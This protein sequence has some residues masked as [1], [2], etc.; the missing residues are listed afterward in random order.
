MNSVLEFFRQEDPRFKE[1]PDRE[2]SLFIG[3]TY[4]EFLEDPHFKEIY[5][6]RTEQRDLEKKNKD[7]TELEGIADTEG[8]AAQLVAEAPARAVGAVGKSLTTAGNLA[9][10]AATDVAE[11][12]GRGQI[13]GVGVPLVLP[14]VDA[15]VKNEPL[16]SDVEDEELL[17]R[18]GSGVAPLIRLGM[19]TAVRSAPTLAA[20]AA[21]TTAGVPAPLAYGGTMATQT[22]G[23][24]GSVPEAI[25]SGAIGAIL[26]VVGNIGRKAAGTALSGLVRNG[27]L[28][29]ESET[30]QKVVE[31]I[32]S[33]AAVQGLL[34]AIKIPQY[35]QMNPEERKSALIRSIAANMTFAVMELPQFAKGVPSETQ[36]A[37][38]NDAGYM[39]SRL[40][41]KGPILEAS[42][43]E[44][45]GMLADPRSAQEFQKVV[46]GEEPPAATEQR[47]AA[48]QTGSP[49]VAPAETQAEAKPSDEQAREALLKRGGVWEASTPVEGHRVSGI[50]TVAEANDLVSSA[51]KGFDQALQP[52]DRS[53]E[54]SGN[55]IAEI[56][57]KFEP[58]RLGDAPTTD[59]GAPIIDE[60]NQVLSGNGRTAALRG[61]YSAEN[62]SKAEAYRAF[63]LKQAE[64]MGSPAEV[65]ASIKKMKQPVL[66]RQVSDLSGLSKEEFAR[67]SNQQQILG[68][69]EA[70]KAA[71]DAKVVSAIADLWR[72]SEEGDVLASSN[73]DFL[74]AF[75]KGT[76]DQAELLTKEGYNAG[77][78]T[79]RVRN[80][81]L[82]NLVGSD[83]IGRE[84]LGHLLERGDEL[85]LRNVVAGVMNAAPA[86]VKVRE[87]KPDY[88]VSGVL[89]KALIDLVNLK[90]EGVRVEDYVKQMD[91]LTDPERSAQSD[92]LVEKLANAKSVK[93][94]TE[95]LGKFA[96]RAQKIDAAR[97]YVWGEGAGR[98]KLLREVFQENGKDRSS[99]NCQQLELKQRVRHPRRKQWLPK[100]SRQLK[101]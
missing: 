29:G 77:A 89:R 57:R 24:T 17:K 18:K 81:V 10:G 40:L 87:L 35:M 92:F 11:Y 27:W 30:T 63:I 43:E 34:E 94:V 78:L 28:S 60:R 32:S 46:K 52:R 48:P 88:D 7:L 4:P 99:R 73:R 98:E 84:L 59:L 71:A 26:P 83:P 95:A 54:A 8:K 6:M 50:W 61:V 69:G 23:E 67:Q 16:P 56:V 33:Q 85:G 5:G 75:V 79:K 74:N 2:L 101:H 64:A 39:V 44:I 14:N 76:G 25:E 38:V 1:V 93:G 49:D 90:R 97:G 3:E 13:P 41:E 86:L 9:A 68:M 47:D 91:L 15:A 31:S 96:E 72:P 53:R 19:R 51:D 70:E 21:M 37:L 20:G 80:A 55:Q 66:V 36:Q 45:A 42:P 22:Y 100:R 12:L 58:E 65:I 82:G 62:Q